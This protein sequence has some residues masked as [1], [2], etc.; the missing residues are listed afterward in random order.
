M[1]ADRVVTAMDPGSYPRQPGHP[2]EGALIW[3]WRTHLARIWC[4]QPLTSGLSTSS[5]YWRWTRSSRRGRASRHGDE[6]GARRLPALP[7]DPAA[8][9]GRPALARPGPVRA[10]L[11]PLQPDPVHP[12]LPVRVR[13]DP[14]RP[15]GA[16]DLG[17]SSPPVTPSTGTRRAWRPPPARSGQGL[18]NAVG[19]AMA[20]RRERGLLD[21]DAAAGASPFDHHIYVLRLRRRHRGG[22]Q[23]RGVVARRPPAAR[24]PGRDLRRQPDLDRGRHQHRQVRGRLRP[25]RGLRLAR[26]AGRLAAARRLRR[27]RRGAVRGAASP[28]GTTPSQPSF[29]ALRTIIGW[30]APNKQ[31]TGEAHGSA[32]G[33]DEVAATK[34]ILGFDPDESFPVED[35]AVAHAREVADR[36]KRGPR[37]RGRSRSPPGRR[38]ARSAAALLDRLAARALP[39]GWAAAL[40]AFAADPKGDGDPRR[41]PARCSTPWP[42]VLP[43]LWGGSA[44]L[45]ESN[46][47]TMKG[48]PSFIPA[49]H[50]TTHVPRQPVRPDPA[51]RHPRARDGR[52]PATGSRCTG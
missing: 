27:G 24:Q 1:A 19:M 6:P 52:D 37:R 12:A 49:E 22:H 44:D 34:E 13:P 33:A 7:A 14:G 36:G 10:V 18:A 40:P 35:E 50:Q 11:R 17:Q 21:P 48:E 25:L 31:N 2:V 20:A 29:I 26:A 30:P 45:A 38:P 9:P 46:N 32:L 41:P 16:A 5:G 3:R 23:P 15:Q 8:R 39:D 43:E 51:L 42:P 28:P 47:T 4:G